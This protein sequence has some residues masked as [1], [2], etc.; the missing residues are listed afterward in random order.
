MDQHGKVLFFNG[1]WDNA[2]KYV[3]KVESVPKGVVPIN[4]QLYAEFLRFKIDSAR[5]QYLSAIR[6]YTRHKIL[7]DSIANVQKMNELEVLN[8]RY[9]TAQKEHQLAQNAQQIAFLDR[10]RTLSDELLRKTQDSAQQAKILQEQRLYIVGNESRQRADSL[11]HA[12]ETNRLLNIETALS[13]DLLAQ[14]DSRRNWMIAGGVLLAMLLLVTYSRYL[15]KQRN[16]RQ[17][18]QQ[19]ALITSKNDS[20]Q[21]LVHEKE[22]LLKEVHHRVKNNLQVVMS[23]L[24]IQSH[25]RKMIRRFLPS[26]TAKTG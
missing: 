20:L 5:M 23:L 16:N 2:E 7:N 24:N 21:K 11:R 4:T 15:L 6:H 14:A 22:W 13:K 1:Q 3:T 8:V 12:K 25:Y 19:Q 26:G 17:L 10:A 9:Q 18:E